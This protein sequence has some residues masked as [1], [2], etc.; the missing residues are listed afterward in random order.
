MEPRRSQLIRGALGRQGVCVRAVVVA[1]L[2]GAVM[3]LAACGGSPAQTDPF[4]GTWRMES[5]D[6]VRIVIAEQDGKHTL[7]QGSPGGSN[8]VS[9]A[10]LD[11]QGSHLRGTGLVTSS[12]EGQMD[13]AID[14]S[15]EHIDFVVSGEGLSSPITTTLTKLSDSTGTPTPVP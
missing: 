6:H 1:F 4:V 12:V 2:V 15:G 8:Y 9:I 7:F 11:R 14:D 10:M 3:M 5:G 13:L